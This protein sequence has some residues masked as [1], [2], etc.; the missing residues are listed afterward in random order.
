MQGEVTAF[1]EQQELDPLPETPASERLSG[2][3]RES[4][5]SGSRPTKQRKIDSGEDTEFVLSDNRQDIARLAVSFVA[6]TACTKQTR[7]SMAVMLIPRIL[8]VRLPGPIGSYRR[9]KID[10]CSKG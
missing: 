7:L 6:W 5:A 10:R 1:L 2:E 9:L 3:K 8:H 4:P